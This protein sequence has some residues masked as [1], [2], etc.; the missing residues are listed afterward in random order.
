VH[1][2]FSRL[3][4]Y[5]DE[6]GAQSAEARSLA[7]SAAVI[8]QLRQAAAAGDWDRLASLLVPLADSGSTYAPWPPSAESSGIS[9]SPREVPASQLLSICVPEVTVLRAEV[10]NRT[11]I[12]ALLLALRHAAPEAFV[13]SVTSSAPDAAASDSSP[14]APGSAEV[15]ALAEALAASHS[16]SSVAPAAEA[17]QLQASVAWLMSLHGAIA[18]GDWTDAVAALLQPL[19]Q[20]VGAALSKL[21]PDMH[22]PSSTGP[23]SASLEALAAPRPTPPH[24]AIAP[25]VA[26][27]FGVCATRAALIGVVDAMRRGS[28]VLSRSDGFTARVDRIGVSAEHVAD[29]LAA[30]RTVLSA[31]T[32][33]AVAAASSSGSGAP[34]ALASDQLSRVITAADCIVMLRQV[35]RASLSRIAVRLSLSR[36]VD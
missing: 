16:A 18:Q 28:L 35:G 26:A 15:R 1:T 9:Q 14:P 32:E 31:A 24:T 2:L 6:L 4:V 30:A 25:H 29:A 23:A 5:S 10:T 13:A 19:P 36:T 27:L 22:P 12:E 21:A 20:H 34:V 7:A 3:F 8:L 33:V 11:I 17:V